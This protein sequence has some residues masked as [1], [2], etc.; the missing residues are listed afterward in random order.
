MTN[1]QKQDDASLPFWRHNQL[2][3]TN[4]PS[5]F[6]EIQ[7]VLDCFQTTRASE[8]RTTN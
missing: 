2:I 3:R 4:K 8:P 5:P 7:I 1:H 6:N